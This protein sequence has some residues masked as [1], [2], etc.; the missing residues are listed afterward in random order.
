MADYTK[1][2]ALVDDD[3]FRRRIQMALWIAAD[4][5]LSDPAASAPQKAWATKNL[6]GV[7]AAED[8]MRL[9]IR[10]SANSTIGAAGDDAQDSDIQFVVS[11]A[12]K[13]LA[14]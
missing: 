9:A 11:Q 10:A 5:I 3:G 7:A 2:R 4:N 13:E 1:R 12:I 8:I 6:K 14:A